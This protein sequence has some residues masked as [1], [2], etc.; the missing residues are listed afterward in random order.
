MSKYDQDYFLVVKDSEDQ[1][2]PELAATDNTESRL[3]RYERQPIGSAPLVFSN[4]WKEDNLQAKVKDTVADILFDGSNLMVAGR[5][6]EHLVAYDIPDLG[7]HPAIYIDDRD[8]WHED[9]WYLAFA[10]EF[11]C[12]DRSTSSYNPR[13]IDMGG[14]KSYKVRSYSLNVHLLDKTPLERRL[15]FKMGG[16]V[17]GKVFCHQS[18]ESIFRST[19]S[20]GASNGAMLKE[21]VW[22]GF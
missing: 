10:Q 4:G 13:A 3:Y 9:Y 21:I 14:E 6:R 7:I 8:V 18:L 2:L 15:L 17:D 5:I 22:K 20:S 11:D 16:T 12:W 19:G 1:R